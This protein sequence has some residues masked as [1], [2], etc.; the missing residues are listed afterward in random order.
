M[1]IEQFNICSNY[2]DKK[3][4]SR[5]CIMLLLTVTKDGHCSP[6]LSAYTQNIRIYSWSCLSL[7]QLKIAQISTPALIYSLFCFCKT[8]KKNSS[9]TNDD[10][11]LQDNN[12]NNLDFPVALRQVIEVNRGLCAKCNSIE[13]T[14][15][16]FREIVPRMIYYRFYE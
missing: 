14:P 13:K 10:G 2:R 7:P 12:D 5:T 9:T 11:K 8:R 6:F 15:M 4:L 16:N 1:L 3:P